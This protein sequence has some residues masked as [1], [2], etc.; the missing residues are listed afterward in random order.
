MKAFI[1][2]LRSKFKGLDDI[3]VWH[4][5]CGAWGGVRPGATHL[6][7]KIIPCKLSPGLDGTMRDLAVVRIVE[8]SVGLVHPDQVNDFYDSMHS[9]L[10]KSGVTGV[11]VDVIYALE[12]DVCDE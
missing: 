6:N 10:A 3:Y 2:D 12:Y 5:L 9:H 8:G 7:L 11:K 4:T 1:M